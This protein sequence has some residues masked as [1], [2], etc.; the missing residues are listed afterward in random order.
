MHGISE[1]SSPTQTL[2]TIATHYAMTWQTIYYHVL[3]MWY[4]LEPQATM[5]EVMHISLHA[6]VAKYQPSSWQLINYIIMLW[7]HLKLCIDSQYTKTM[8]NLYSRPWLRYQN[9]SFVWI[10]EMFRY[11]KEC[12]YYMEM[13]IIIMD[14]MEMLISCLLFSFTD[15]L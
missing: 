3:W 1:W 11:V 14:Y 6:W 13:L 5:C 12:S 10:S 8:N 7:F 9:K 15:E 2:Q 4:E